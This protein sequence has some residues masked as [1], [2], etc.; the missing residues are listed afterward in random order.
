M[1]KHSLPIALSMALKQHALASDI[2]NDDE[3]KDIVVKLDSL[4][5]KIQAVKAKA[6]AKRA[7]KP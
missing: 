7:N 1:H 3:L 2:A 6:L 5:E 4:H